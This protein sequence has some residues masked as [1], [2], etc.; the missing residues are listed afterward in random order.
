MILYGMCD[1]FRSVCP[2]GDWVPPPPTT[3]KK[4]SWNPP[5]RD[6]FY[7]C[8]TI[9]IYFSFFILFCVYAHTHFNITI[10]SLP[11]PSSLTR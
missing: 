9:L 11:S 7:L 8:F 3:A 10:P 2:P 5:T 1:M 4:I 6:Y